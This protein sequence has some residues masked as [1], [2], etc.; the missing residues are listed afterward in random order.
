MKHSA[1]ILLTGFLLMSG[2]T[3]RAQQ[4]LVVQKR[5]SVKNFK[6]QAGDDIALQTYGVD[7]PIR[8]EITKMSDSSLTIDSYINIRLS[9]ISEVLRP[10]RYLQKLSRLFFIRGGIAYV[11]IVGVNGLINNDSPVIDEQTLT[12]SAVM[13]AIGLAMKS[14]YI[15]KLDVISKWQLK[16]IDFDNIPIAED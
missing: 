8:G 16:I 13:I 6:Y 10:R 4:Y 14:F 12:I 1:L 2:Y 15:R 3:V 7:F 9:D 11:A 5:G